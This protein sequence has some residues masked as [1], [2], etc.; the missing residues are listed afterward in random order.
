MRLRAYI[1]RFGLL[2]APIRPLVPG[3]VPYAR[4][5]ATI[6]I[7]YDLGITYSTA[8]AFIQPF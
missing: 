3:Y 4:H 6:G 7:D 5:A 8:D 2:A 1:H